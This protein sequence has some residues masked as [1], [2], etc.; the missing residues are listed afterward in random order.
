MPS[1]N[2]TIIST[3]F[4]STLIYSTITVGQESTPPELEMDIKL[5]PL[6]ASISL[7]S[8]AFEVSDIGVL[9]YN[10]K[11]PVDSNILYGTVGDIN[12]NGDPEIYL[13]GWGWLDG[14]VNPENEPKKALIGLEFNESGANILDLDSQFGVSSSDGTT[15]LKID[16]FDQNGDLDL[17]IGAH[18][19]NPFTPYQNRILLNNNG[20][21]EQKLF[22]PK[23]TMH[24]GEVGDFNGDGYT[25]FIGSA[26]T[27]DWFET[28]GNET[29][30][31][32]L[33]PLD[34]ALFL[35]IND[36]KGDFRPYALNF[37]YD[38]QNAP[39]T[40]KI[41]DDNWTE[42]QIAKN[43]D[44]GF[45]GT[46]SAAAIGNLDDDPEME[47]V[48]VD[49]DS[50]T[51]QTKD[52][53]YV[54]DN[55]KL[56]DN[57]AHGDFFPLPEP[58]IQTSDVFKEART[59]S[60]QNTPSHDIHVKIFDFDNDGLND[61]IVNSI[62]MAET[63]I[64]SG[65]VQFLK[66]KGN[67]VFEDVTDS[68]L[69]NRSYSVWGSHEPSWIDFNNDGFLDIYNAEGS[70]NYEAETE[71]GNLWLP[72]PDS[73]ANEI[74]INTGNGKFVSTFRKEFLDLSTQVND[75]FVENGINSFDGPVNFV[76]MQNALQHYQLSNGIYGF[77]SLTN[78]SPN[79][80]VVDGPIHTQALLI[81]IRAKQKF[82]TGPNGSN[83]AFQG[84]PGFS[85]YYYLTENPDVVTAINSET[86][87]D[88][89]A[90]YLAKGKA[91]GRLAFAKN[92][93]IHGSANN[94]TI[95]LREGDEKAF[96]YAG[97]DSFDGKLGNDVLDG[98]VGVDSAIYTDKLRNYTLT[99]AENGFQVVNQDVYVNHNLINIEKV[100][101]DETAYQFASS[102]NDTDGDGMSDSYEAA[103]GLNS[104]DDSDTNTD[105][106]EDGLNNL[107]ESLI[108][109]SANNKDSDG[110]GFLDVDDIFPLDPLEW[111]DSD[112]DGIGNNADT[113]D[114][115][116]GVD[117]RVEISLGTDPLDATDYPE[118]VSSVFGDYDGDGKAD[119]F[120]R[121]SVTAYNYIKKSESNDVEGLVFGTQ[122]QDIP[123]VGDFDGDGISD[124]AIRRSST[125]MWYI[126]NS[127][128]TNYGSDR[129]DGIQRIRFGLRAE[130][131]PVP[132]DY[133][134]D[135]ITDIAVR[136]PS[137]QMW[138]IRNSTDKQIQ[139]IKFGLQAEDI[140]VVGDYDGDG[141]ADIAVRRPSNQFWYIKNSSNTNFNSSKADGIQRI[142]FG[143]QAED[144]PVVGDY[145]GDG[146]TD[147]AVRR[148][149]DMMWYIKNSTD[150]NIQRIKFGLQVT[151]IPIPADYDGDGKFDVA[152]RRPS[153]YYF[154]SKNSDDSEIKRNKFG[155]NKDY[156]PILAPITEKMSF[157]KRLT[158]SSTTQQIKSTAHADEALQ[159]K[160]YYQEQLNYDS[161]IFPSGKVELSND[162][163]DRPL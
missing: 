161:V 56:A 70:A 63:D 60:G 86:Y 120:A 33:K 66:N 121:N 123:L 50:F 87:T 94:D 154:Y 98:G 127:S 82:Y 21:F 107:T 125:F 43:G 67:L 92:A 64:H 129:N 76:R 2:I 113:D 163:V 148:P 46:G 118:I 26:Y 17:L 85:E 108:G 55:I 7:N 5:N 144:I 22:G 16:D 156:I 119:L 73:Y 11:L 152:V 159:N 62:W 3:L 162:A 77:V 81:N 136:R 31:D 114:D 29:L 157:I 12:N 117:D 128:G 96:G 147:L 93:K 37:N 91:E 83:P 132:A 9:D 109:T 24:E 40:Q 126:K 155:L 122:Q 131:I 48:V 25:D 105:L 6:P 72:V 34:S 47:V 103:N 150:G 88:G 102:E 95:I 160:Q 8:S 89:L 140:P 124:I 78:L 28:V 61:I 99:K 57:Y 41:A 133:D 115:N 106:D 18:N 51:F 54:I 153:T 71:E 68:T 110:D 149:A 151:D 19:E 143:L 58:Y 4:L 101:F 111:L 75:I 112:S 13:G 65:I 84:E 134:G 30:P 100:I 142:K 138:Y 23:V 146:I 49:V 104:N 38:V 36:T 35:Y 139:R 69:Y 130:D 74:L 53:N 10:G 27:T 80:P 137:T 141:K 15:F 45:I 97:D 90:H 44:N 32:N 14:N 1:I 116:D 145:D 20:S 79:T 52:H 158:M 135:G 39:E 42:E 59:S